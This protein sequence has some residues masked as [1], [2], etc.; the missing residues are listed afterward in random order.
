MVAQKGK[1]LLLK[2]K[3]DVLLSYITV[4]GL[5]ARTLA[6]NTQTVDITHSESAQQWRE[7]LQG[8]G[9][10]TGRLSGGGIFRDSQSDALIRQ[11][12]FA[13]TIPDWQIII[14]D[15]G[16]IEGGF[17]IVSLEF[18][19]RHDNE[20][21]FEMTMESAGALAFTAL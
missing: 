12:F 16:L 14:P 7:L 19:G 15:F 1:D 13:G 18:T 4:A 5:R 17:Q 10:K 6:F 3:D 9:V 21:S 2:I 8:A 20:V 11:H